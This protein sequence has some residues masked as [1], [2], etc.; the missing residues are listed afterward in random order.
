MMRPILFLLLVLGSAPLVAQTLVVSPSLEVPDLPEFNTVFIA[1]NG[2]T[3]ITGVRMLKRDG[4]PMREESER[5]A[6]RFDTQ[7]RTIY[8]NHSY[9]RPGSGRDTVSVAYSYDMQGRQTQKLHNGAGG[10]FAYIRE[11]DA[12]DRVVRETYRR[13]AR[14]VDTEAG[15]TPGTITEVSDEQFTYTTVNDTTWRKHYNNYLGLPYREQTFT[16]DHRGYLLKVED[17]Y[18]IS[19]RRSR[20][21]F[22]YDDRGQLASRTEQPDLSQPDIIRHT[23]QYDAVGNVI[24]AELWRGDRQVHREEFLY[25]E[26]T[27]VLKARLRRDLTSGNIQVTK[28]TIHR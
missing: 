26:G 16:K 6:Y 22:T 7:G 18:L 1:R 21:T 12:D 23:W 27:M 20:I 9:G 14:P 25:D 8:G 10:Q 2:I 17:R 3:S 15:V 11:Y 28:Y 4:E 5:H 13:I 24:S 19:E